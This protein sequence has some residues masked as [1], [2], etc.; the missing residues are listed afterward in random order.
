MTYLMASKQHGVKRREITL[1]AVTPSNDG[2]T[3]A[4]AENARKPLSSLNYNDGV[5]NGVK[6][7]LSHTPSRAIHS[8]A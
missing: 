7:N 8:M 2:V 6:H 1:H 4:Y 5:K 3:T